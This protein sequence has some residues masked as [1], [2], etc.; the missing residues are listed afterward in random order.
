MPP[1]GYQSSREDGTSAYPFHHLQCDSSSSSITSAHKLAVV[2][3]LVYVC[4]NSFLGFL[5]GPMLDEGHG[6]HM[7]GNRP[8]RRVRMTAR[9]HL[10]T[11]EAGW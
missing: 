11:D 6:N 1:F 4:V 10:H 7:W 3:G 8:F 9:N 2:F 5:L